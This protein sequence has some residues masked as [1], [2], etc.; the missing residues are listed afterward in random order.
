MV[1]HD[2]VSEIRKKAARQAAKTRT[3]TQKQLKRQKQQTVERLKKAREHTK[4]LTQW[5]YG[6]VKAHPE[7]AKAIAKACIAMALV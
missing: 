7:E 4:K 2:R 5:A 3:E 1:K 6:F